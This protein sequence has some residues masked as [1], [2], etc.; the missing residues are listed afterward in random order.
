MHKMICDIVDC[1]FTDFF[2]LATKVCNM[3]TGKLQTGS[4]GAK[5]NAK[6]KSFLEAVLVNYRTI[7]QLYNYN[8]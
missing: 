8:R 3:G 4:G 2:T 7:S 1:N 6:Y 5:T